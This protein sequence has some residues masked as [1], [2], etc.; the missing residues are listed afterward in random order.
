MIIGNNIEE[1]PPTSERSN[2]RNPR[3]TDLGIKNA[4]GDVDFEDVARNEDIVR[5]DF[6]EVFLPT[7]GY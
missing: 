2:F 7:I 1:Y 4:C 3:S 6:F 5:C